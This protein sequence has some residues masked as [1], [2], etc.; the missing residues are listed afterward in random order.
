MTGG[1][2]GSLLM[3]HLIRCHFNYAFFC[4]NIIDCNENSYLG[5]LHAFY[6]CIDFF[7]F[8][9]FINVIRFFVQ[10]IIPENKSEEIEM[11]KQY[12]SQWLKMSTC[13]EKHAELFNDVGST[14]KHLENNLPKEEL[15][16]LVTG[17]LHLV[18][19]FIALINANLSEN[20]YQ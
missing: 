5:Q 8:I 2:D 20:N 6:H 3:K 18:G 19:A 9:Y 14:L 4:P 1:R 7:Y 16:V 13:D 15:H 11:S 17:S 12:Y 10:E